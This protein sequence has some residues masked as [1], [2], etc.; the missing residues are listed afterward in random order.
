MTD[1]LRRTIRVRCSV[2]HAFRVFT[3]QVD[4]WWPP[5]HRKF[6][7]S[8]LHFETQEGSRFFERSAAG[9]EAVL[10]EVL[11]C[12]PPHHI[13]FTWHPGKIEL[14]THVAIS[15]EADGDDTIVNVIHAEGDA[16]L[17]D[18][19]TERAQLFTRGWSHVLAA[20]ETHIAEAREQ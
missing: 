19:W 17:G 5:G 6:E 3:E 7:D 1:P 2:A 12:E 15:F 20:F 9:E 13:S 18:K 14:P 8:S 10:G 11:T 4:L 16:A